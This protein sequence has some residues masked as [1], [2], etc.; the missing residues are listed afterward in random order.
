MGLFKRADT[1]ATEQ[2]FFGEE[3]TEQDY[4]TVRSSL[5]K[6]ESNEILSN[7]PSGE[8]DIKGG[9][10]FLERFFEK[11]MIDWSMVD[12][13]G[14]PVK[15]TVAEYRK[16]EAG[17]AR[18]IDEQLGKHLNKVLGREIEQAEGESLT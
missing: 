6:G 9:L 7:A 16:M 11:V 18:L 3:G 17:G 5:T 4:I 13:D 10:A 15:P 1:G 14:K 8:R 12:D 2:Y